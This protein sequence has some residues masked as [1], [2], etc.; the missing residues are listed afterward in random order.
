MQI[1]VVDFD[2]ARRAKLQGMLVAMNVCPAEI[3]P[4]LNIRGPIQRRKKRKL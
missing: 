4:K 1:G 2:A 3:L